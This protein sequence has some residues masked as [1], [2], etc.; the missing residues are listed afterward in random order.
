MQ[1]WNKLCL[2]CNSKEVREVNSNKYNRRIMEQPY[3]S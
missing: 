3:K 2:K 1:K